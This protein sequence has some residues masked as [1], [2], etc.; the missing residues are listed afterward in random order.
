MDVKEHELLGGEAERHWYYRGKAEAL[1]CYLPTP[2]PRN[3]LDVGA[4]SGIFSRSLLR[5]TAAE[6]ALCVD[7]G[8]RNDW[9]EEVNGKPLR[10][11]RGCGSTDADLILLMDVLE[12]VDDDAGLLAEYRDKAPRASKFM[13]TVPAFQFLWSGHDVFLEH[14]RRYNLPEL[15][16]LVARAGLRCERS[17]YYFGFVL[18]LAASVRLVGRLFGQDRTVA[19]SHLKRHTPFVNALLRGLCAA[20]LPVLTINRLAGLSVFCL[21]SKP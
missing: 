7:P 13:I 16:Q 10:F 18:P 9:D 8:Y 3:I 4:G 5:T 19:R 14:K 12:H 15:E 17:S 11:R 2:G 6:S 21:C 1:R 20:E